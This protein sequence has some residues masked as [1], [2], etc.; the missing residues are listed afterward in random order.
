MDQFRQTYTGTL[1]VAGGYQR[2]NGQEALDVGR[3][4]LIAIGR[5]FLTNPDLVARLENDW[6]QTPIDPT[7]FYGTAGAEGYVTYKPY[8]PEA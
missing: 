4:D 7:V 5:P 3:A 8:Q 6:P 2:A 1:M